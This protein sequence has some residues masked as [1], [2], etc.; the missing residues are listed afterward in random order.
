LK[1]S[2]QVLFDESVFLSPGDFKLVYFSAGARD[3][4]GCSKTFSVRFREFSVGPE[5]SR[6]LEQASE[7]KET[8]HA[9]EARENIEL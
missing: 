3:I 8:E 1:I 9:R 7:V 5:A 2:L 6:P 4:L